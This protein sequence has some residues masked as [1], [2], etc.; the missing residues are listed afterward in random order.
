MCGRYVPLPRLRPAS[1]RDA[2]TS[3]NIALPTAC[4][5]SSSE[6]RPTD[7]YDAWLDPTHQD[8]HDLRALLGQPAGGHLD[9]RPAS[10]MVNN[11]RNH[12]PHRVD[13]AT[14]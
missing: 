12:N 11:V 13:E 8:P 9:E 1:R 4:G 7:H 5:S 6:H 14:G 10:T 2:R 3:W